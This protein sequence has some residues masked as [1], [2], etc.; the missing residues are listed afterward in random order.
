LLV[1]IGAQG[2]NPIGVALVLL[3]VA[4]LS[5]YLVSGRKVLP[6]LPAVGS[7]AV[8]ITA[9][10]IVSTAAATGAGQWQLGGGS[11]AI[12]FM[13]LLAVFST[14]LP[15]TLLAIGLRYVDA[16]RASIYSTIEPI[17]TVIAAGFILGERIGTFQ[18]F[19][20]ALILAAVVWLRLE[21]PLPQSEYP[22][23]FDSP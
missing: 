2:V 8:I 7:A 9:T 6:S 21:R 3:A 22:T 1:G 4:A 18:Y 15:I 12:V 14:A 16:G 19:G 5:L 10:A 17:I 20:G 23:P 11:R 13:L